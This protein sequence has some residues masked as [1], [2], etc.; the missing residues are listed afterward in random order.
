V[1][2]FFITAAVVYFLL[3]LPIQKVQER[4][5]KNPSEAQPEASDIELLA[6]IRNLLRRGQGLPVVDGLRPAPSE[7]AMS[8][9]PA[10]STD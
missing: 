3:V 8:S 7:E 1:I 2:T 10:S 9:A 5:T 6:E 4:R